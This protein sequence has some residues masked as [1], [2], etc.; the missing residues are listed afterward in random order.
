MLTVAL[1]LAAPI[2]VWEGDDLW[3]TLADLPPGA[4]VV[5][6][7]GT[8][9]TRQGSGSWYRALVW[10]GT[11]AEPIV[12]RAAEAES[13]R[14]EGDPAGSQNVLDLSGSWFTLQGFEIVYGSHGLRLGGSSHGAVVDNRV[15]DTADVGISMNRDGQRYESM[16]LRGNEV[17]DTGGTGECFYLGCNEGS[18]TV[19]DSIV[20]YNYC[21]DTAGTEQGD[22]IELKSGSH[23]NVIRHNVVVN[24]NYPG[25]TL[26]GTYGAPRN[27]AEG[28]LV[29]GTVDNG[30]QVVGE[31]EVVGNIVIDAGAYGIY[32]K[33]SQGSTPD[34]LHIAHNTVLRAG[35]ACFRANDWDGVTDAL[36]ANN[37]FLCDGGTA[38]RLGGGTGAARFVGN[39][40]TG[41]SAVSEG[42]RD[43]GSAAALVNDPGEP[44]LWPVDGSLLVD[45]GESDGATPTDFDCRTR[46]S[47]P[48]VG[49]YGW[50]AGGGPGWP[51][52]PGFKTCAGDADPGDTGGEDSGGAD[53][54]PGDSGPTGETGATDD[55]GDPTPLDPPKTPSG[56]GCST[57]DTTAGWGAGAV[58]LWLWAAR[59]GPGVRSGSRRSRAAAPLLRL[60]APA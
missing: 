42:V 18:C 23:G 52:R 24:T 16:L 43:G 60:R 36:V 19:A 57:P 46:D 37:A 38:I 56:C 22:G 3:A 51:L 47:T 6:H 13:V 4:E 49:A 26:Y 54:G 33:A 27:R 58:A 15:H 21:H 48:D 29:W 10:E 41:D 2:D 44:D 11:E 8:W 53:S 40:A 14:I 9:T 17:Y 31:V 1:A 34:A 55:D 20:E 7:G 32:S 50:Y 59:R 25:I 28:N 5:V 39:V 12:V 30:I 45:G 35:D